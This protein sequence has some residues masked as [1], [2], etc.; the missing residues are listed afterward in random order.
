MHHRP[1]LQVGRQCPASGAWP[2]Y[3]L[4]ELQDLRP[5]VREAEHK[6]TAMAVDDQ[7]WPPP[8]RRNCV[9]GCCTSPRN[10]PALPAPPL[11]IAADWPWTDDRITA[12]QRLVEPAEP[13]AMGARRPASHQHLNLLVR[14]VREVGTFEVRALAASLSDQ[15]S[16]IDVPINNGAA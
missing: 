5:L 10:S 4:T 11:R 1:L 3:V 14:D 8:S 13:G 15:T 9:T 2:V 6:S 16:H 7:P 12:F